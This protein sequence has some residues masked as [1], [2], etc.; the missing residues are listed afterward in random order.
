MEPKRGNMLSSENAGCEAKDQKHK[1]CDPEDFVYKGAVGAER[2]TDLRRSTL[3]TRL[4]ERKLF[5]G[6]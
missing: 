2:G 1:C 4:G 6:V 5:W 3:R